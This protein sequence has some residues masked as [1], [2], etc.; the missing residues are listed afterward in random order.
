MPTR[1]YITSSVFTWSRLIDKTSDVSWDVIVRGHVNQFPDRR[2]QRVSPHEKDDIPSGLG[3]CA[4]SV[5]QISRQMRRNCVFQC[6]EYRR[7]HRRQLCSAVYK[8]FGL[9]SHR[10]SHMRL[11]DQACYQSSTLTS[12]FESIF[13]GCNPTH[14]VTAMCQLQSFLI[15]LSLISDTSGGVTACH[16][17]WKILTFAIVAVVVILSNERFQ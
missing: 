17:L 1:V 11:S 4:H 14:R 3:S 12:L 10:S 2:D 6:K 9:I 7:R 15:R 13:G 16:L 8:C 5:R